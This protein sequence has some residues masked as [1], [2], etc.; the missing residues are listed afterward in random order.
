MRVMARFD[1]PTTPDIWP[2]ESPRESACTIT[3]E[4]SSDI[5][6]GI[7]VSL[8]VGRL[9]PLS[10]NEQSCHQGAVKD[11]E[12]RRTKVRNSNR[13][14]YWRARGFP[15]ASREEGYDLTGI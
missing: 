14:C 6:R 8:L 3:F 4:T 9:L 10:L 12:S 11:F 1:T 2:R 13:G 5:P 15:C 7:L